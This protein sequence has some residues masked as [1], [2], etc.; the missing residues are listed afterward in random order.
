MLHCASCFSLG[1]FITLTKIGLDTSHANLSLSSFLRD[2]LLGFALAHIAILSVHGAFHRRDR[3]AEDLR[4]TVTLVIRYASA[5]QWTA[6]YDALLLL[7]TQ[8]VDPVVR[9]VLPLGPSII[10]AAIGLTVVALQIPIIFGESSF[11]YSFELCFAKIAGTLACCTLVLLVLKAAEEPAGFLASKV[12][13]IVRDRNYLVGRRLE[14][15]ASSAS[16][17]TYS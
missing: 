13:G 15:V 14:N 4:T 5:E 3:W 2:Q 12:Q 17:Q 16:G 6:L 7:E 1:L 11:V 8:F 9:R 10:A